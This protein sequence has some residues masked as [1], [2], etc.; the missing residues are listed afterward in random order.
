MLPVRLRLMQG[1]GQTWALLSPVPGTSEETVFLLNHALDQDFQDAATN[2]SKLFSLKPMEIL[3]LREWEEEGKSRLIRVIMDERNGELINFRTG[4]LS[5]LD[6]QMTQ[7]LKKSRIFFKKVLRFSLI[8]FALLITISML[9]VIGIQLRE[10]KQRHERTLQEIQRKEKIYQKLSQKL[11]ALEL[12]EKER[13]YVKGS[14]S[15][16]K[17]IYRQQTNSVIELPPVKIQIEPLLTPEEK[18]GW[19]ESW[20][21]RIFKKSS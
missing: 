4:T 14:L 6:L 15:P 12:V 1:E 21:N 3:W 10:E 18:E 17:R 20:Q 8:H 11:L 13:E 5:S 16:Y 7:R 19:M 9:A 2:I